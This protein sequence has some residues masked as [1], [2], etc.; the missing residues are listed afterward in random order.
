MNQPFESPEPL[1]LDDLRVGQRFTSGTYKMEEERMKAFAAEFDPQPFHL[2]EASAQ[3]SIFRGLAAS[4]WH[5]AA[6]TM[7]LMV[8]GGLPFAGELVG[9]GG[10]IT[11][12]KPVRPG[13]TL[14]VESEILEITPLRS[15]PNRGVVTVRSVTMNQNDELVQVLTSKILVSK[16]GEE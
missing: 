2:D 5:T 16:R 13:D 9:L 6:A 1:Y 11:W 8:T 7:R 15:K 3:R 12:T 10:E 4:G 14:R